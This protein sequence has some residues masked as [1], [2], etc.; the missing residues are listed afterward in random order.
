MLKSCGCRSLPCEI[1]PGSPTMS[2]CFGDFHSGKIILQRP[3]AHNER[4]KLL[5]TAKIDLLHK[6]ISKKGRSF[7]ALLVVGGK[8]G[9]EFAPRAPKGEGKSEKI[10]QRGPASRRAIAWLR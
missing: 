2:L 7:S 8:V 3:I 5:A 6:F 9:F 1:R 10:R 4:K